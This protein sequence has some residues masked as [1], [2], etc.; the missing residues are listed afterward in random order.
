MNKYFIGFILIVIIVFLYIQNKKEN[1]GD[2]SNLYSNNLANTIVA[3]NTYANYIEN[4]KSGNRTYDDKLFDDLIS[5]ENDP[6]D[7]LNTGVFKCLTECSG[8]C[9]EYGMTGLAYCFPSEK[10]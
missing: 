7:P 6:N 5:Y 3:P 9:V 1:M 4:I 10:N 2:I 8:N